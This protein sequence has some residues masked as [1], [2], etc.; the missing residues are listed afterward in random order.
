MRK[1]N[2]DKQNRI[3]EVAIELFAKNGYHNTTV[4]MI[5]EMANMSTGNFYIYFKSK[6]D[7][8]TVIFKDLWIN[9]ANEIEKIVKNQNLT[10]LEKYEALIDAIFDPFLI[11]PNLANVFVNEHLTI[12]GIGNKKLLSN[13]MKFIVLGEEVI[14]EGIKQQVF[15][16]YINVNIFSSFVYGAIRYLLHLWA[17]NQFKYPLN[18]VRDNVKYISINGLLNNLGLNYEKNPMDSISC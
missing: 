9:I 5:T 18:I 3:I 1:K 13:Y 17:E 2:Q 15:C 11:N 14:R 4:N 16:A 10:P 12:M 7:L 6:E 8:L